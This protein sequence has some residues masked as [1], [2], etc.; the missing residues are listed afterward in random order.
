MG[1]S[2]LIAANLRND[3]YSAGVDWSVSCADAGG[4]CGTLSSAHTL[5]DTSTINGTVLTGGAFGY[6]VPNAAV[7]Y[8]APSTVPSGGTVTITAA[9]TTDPTVTYSAT[10][11]ITK[12]NANGVTDALNG[13]FAFY[14]IG[15]DTNYDTFTSN[16][17]G[18][19]AIIGSL[20]GNGTG[21]FYP[22]GEADMMDYD[23]GYS[24]SGSASYT[25]TAGGQGQI[26]V[27]TGTTNLGKDPATTFN[28]SFI[29]EDH[30]LLSAADS[31]SA[32][33]GM[34]YRQNMKDIAAATTT[35]GL[36]LSGAYTLSMT[37]ASRDNPNQRFF[38]NGA[39]NAAAGTTTRGSHRRKARRPA[40]RVRCILMISHRP[41]GDGSMPSRRD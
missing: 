41:S 35:A 3:L 24:S 36:P 11:T 22:G 30:A 9:S 2:E 38:L 29:D 8:T 1:K 10:L 40:G 16:K 34:L 32:G 14:Y 33:T 12:P 7:A 4:N 26:S 27:Y 17:G 31:F 5:A 39:L 25:M 18:A 13:Q 21:S 23:L 37:G 6:T 19:F 20:I 28:I 15:R